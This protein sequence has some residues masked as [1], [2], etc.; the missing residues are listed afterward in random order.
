[1]IEDENQIACRYCFED[2]SSLHLITPCKCSGSLK[3]VHEECFLKFLNSKLE[4]YLWSNE[5][6]CEI[7]K[8][9]LNIIMT[10]TSDNIDFGLIFR[11]TFVTIIFLSVI[12][13]ILILLLG[14]IINNFNDGVFYNFHDTFKNHMFDGYCVFQI[15]HTFVYLWRLCH[16]PVFLSFI[17]LKRSNKNCL[18]CF[19]QFCIY[20]MT[21][22]FFYMIYAYFRIVKDFEI[23]RK[24]I[25]SILSL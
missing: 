19:L 14:G 11:K 12:V 1:M 21:S 16:E 17:T 9:E 13:F 18:I 24:S 20:I 10:E 15:S 8:H 22:F 4:S 6:R 2:D 25:T 5:I 7:C 3:Y 23:K